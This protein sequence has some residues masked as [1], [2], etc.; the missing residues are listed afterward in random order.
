MALS[1]IPSTN[2]LLALLIARYKRIRLLLWDLPTCP[3]CPRTFTRLTARF[4]SPDGRCSGSLDLP[5]SKGS[6]RLH[7]PDWMMRVPAYVRRVLHIPYAFAQEHSHLSDCTSKRGAKKLGYTM[8]IVH[9]VYTMLYIKAYHI[10]LAARRWR[11]R[12]LP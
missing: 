4:I 12:P 2:Q 6:L 1:W 5:T 3:I 10:S 11:P 9:Q 8:Q 7:L